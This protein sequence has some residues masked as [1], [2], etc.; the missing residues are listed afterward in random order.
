MPN[1][2]I[3]SINIDE[4]I[5][6]RG[7]YLH[8]FITKREGEKNF[9]LVAIPYWDNKYRLPEFDWWRPFLPCSDF[10]IS[11]ES[12][13]EC[14][15]QDA[16]WLKKMRWNLDGEYIGERM[17]GYNIPALIK[18]RYVVKGSKLYFLES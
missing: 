2:D 15:D 3:S 6:Y 16:L 10:G 9:H 7:S 14:R 4:V 18:P 8:I 13:Y 5:E 11:H 17:N 12:F 1:I